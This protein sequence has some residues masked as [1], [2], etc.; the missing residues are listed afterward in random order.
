[1]NTISLNPFPIP[2]GALRRRLRVELNKAGDVIAGSRQRDQTTVEIAKWRYDFLNELNKSCEEEAIRDRFI[3]RIGKILTDPAIGA[4]R[5]SILAARHMVKWLKGHHYYLS[6]RDRLE[7]ELEEVK[8][9]ISWSGLNDKMTH[10]IGLWQQDFSAALNKYRNEEGVRDYFIS[11]LQEMLCDP[12]TFA[13]LN[14]PQLGSDGGTYDELS[15]KIYK[16]RMPARFHN[17]SP[18]NPQDPTPFKTV[19]HPVAGYLVDWLKGHNACLYS[20]ELEQTYL[21]L[22]RGRPVEN[23]QEKERALN[24][25]VKAVEEQ[26]ALSRKLNQE[27]FARLNQ[28]VDEIVQPLIGMA[29]QIQAYQNR[30][31]L[32]LNNL[33][34]TLSPLAARVNE[35][36]RRVAI[37]VQ[38][39]QA[40]VQEEMRRFAELREGLRAQI[41]ELK[42]G[43]ERLER[44]LAS[45]MGTIEE[46]KVQT[47]ILEKQITQLEQAIK[48]MKN[49]WA[50][51][52]FRIASTALFSVFGTV[53]LRAM[54]ESSSFGVGIANLRKGAGLALRINL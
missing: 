23:R 5:E 34:G 39:E 45:V 38:E 25:E 8:N 29:A 35:S 44:Q 54:L 31:Q 18:R 6:L 17:R 30:E 22:S 51:D 12:V 21:R 4:R 50:S 14:A 11:I 19:P 37:L 16:L 20:K 2:P 33:A 36:A 27:K 24:A 9:V 41:D 46:E 48:E 26:F 15:L 40:R 32:A 3:S 42:S 1:M 49:D 52:M 7:T 43:N 10:L 47:L 13:P 53:A 28:R